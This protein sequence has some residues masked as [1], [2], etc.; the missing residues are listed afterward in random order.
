MTSQ[1]TILLRNLSERLPT[2]F[3]KCLLYG[4][5]YVCLVVGKLKGNSVLAANS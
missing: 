5:G 1:V 3:S 2:D 4:A